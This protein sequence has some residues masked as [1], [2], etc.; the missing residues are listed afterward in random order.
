MYNIIKT[1]LGEHQ[2]LTLCPVYKIELAIHHAF[3]S[4][5]LNNECNTDYVN[6]FYLFK[7]ANLRWKFS[8][9]QSVFKGTPYFQYKQICDACACFIPE[10]GKITSLFSKNTE[11][12]TKKLKTIQLSLQICYS[13]NPEHSGET[14]FLISDQ[15]VA[16]G[17]S[18]NAQH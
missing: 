3:E 14:A 16:A 5:D 15:A 17:Q 12:T 11:R 13:G 4:S 18:I 2:L 7:D 1:E 9:R 8:R 6:I 10:R